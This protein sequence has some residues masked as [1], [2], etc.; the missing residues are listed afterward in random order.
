MKFNHLLILV[1]NAP[2]QR[3]NIFLPYSASPLAPSFL[4]FLKRVPLN[5]LKQYFVRTTSHIKLEHGILKKP[6]N[7]TKKRLTSDTIQIFNEIYQDDDFSRQM[8]SEKDLLD[9]NTIDRNDAADK[10]ATILKIL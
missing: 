3:V 10:Y 6:I 7:E 9:C 1:K 8:S 2:I 4:R 5:N